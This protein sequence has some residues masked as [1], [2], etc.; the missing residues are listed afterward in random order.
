A[1]LKEAAPAISRFDDEQKK[2]E[3]A[4]KKADED[5]AKA[6]AAAK[7]TLVPATPVPAPAA[8]APNV[9]AAP[10]RSGPDGLWKGSYECTAARYGVD[11][12]MPLQIAVSGGVGTWT[13]PGGPSQRGNQSITVRISGA[14]V[15]VSR[16]Y[17]PANQPGTTVTATMSARYDGN[18]I[19]G[20]GPEANSGGRNCTI[21]LTRGS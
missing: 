7:A 14:Q 13:R 1:L 3:E 6:D 16:V 9:A 12:N 10:Q 19:S 15:A 4:K 2:V 8:T 5:K 17:M 18:A 21:S 20:G 11:F